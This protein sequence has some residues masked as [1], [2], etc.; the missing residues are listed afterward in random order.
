MTPTTSRPLK[1]QKKGP[2][3]LPFLP[4]TLIGLFLLGLLLAPLILSLLVAFT[5]E[6]TLDVPSITTLSWRW[7]DAFFND[8]AW[9][10]GSGNSFLV[11]G[12]TMLIAVVT[13]TMAA[14]AF[15]RH[16]FPG[17]GVWSLVILVPLFVPPVVLGMQSL[18]WHQRI[19]LWGNLFS[20][21]IAHALIATPIAFMVMRATLK[22]VDRQLEEAAAGLG[23]SPFRVFWRVTLPLSFPGILVS[24]F[25][26]FII[27]LNEFVMSLFLAT[28]KTQ[29]ISTIIWPQLQYNP[30]PIVAAASA[31]LLLL[32]VVI[33]GVASRLLGVKRLI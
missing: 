3:N 25:F 11:A 13:G 5:P 12:L 17:K 14:L 21:A 20:L 24:A 33:L 7:I 8:P 28:P 4:L 9:Q 6:Q 18:V 19:G 22:K 30:T 32:T 15:E 27:S 2:A 31:V 23:A 10:K 1:V 29:T 16:E 26:A